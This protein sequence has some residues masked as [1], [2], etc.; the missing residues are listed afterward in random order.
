MIKHKLLFLAGIW[1]IIIGLSY[2]ISPHFLD[3]DP[4]T[5]D[6]VIEIIQDWG[7]IIILLFGLPVTALSY[8]DLTHILSRLITS[9]YL[10]FLGWL[11]AKMSI[12]GYEEIRQNKLPY[13]MVNHPTIA[14]I[15]V[16]EHIFALNMDRQ[17]I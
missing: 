4:N 16:V 7:L 8:L 6:D 15:F 1:L 3:L 12:S 5:G 13:H 2:I 11:N 10:I 17:T 14:I 9:L